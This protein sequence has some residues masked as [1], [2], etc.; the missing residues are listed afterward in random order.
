MP[1][2]W[3]DVTE[4]TLELGVG[5]LVGAGEADGAEAVDVVTMSRRAAAIPEEFADSLSVARSITSEEANAPF[6]AR[7]WNSPYEVGSQVTIVE[8]TEDVTLARVSIDGKEQGQFLVR[9]D[10]IAGM[11]PE[12]ILQHL[13]LPAVPTQI[14]E[15]VVPA[16]TRMQVGI[17]GPQP[18]FLNALGGGI[19]YQLLDEIP[20]ENFGTPRPLK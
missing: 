5:F 18:E 20:K 2:F 15:V 17:V 8:T 6:I 19:Q 12:Q 13:A 14:A 7:G 16:G 10:E 3:G 11:T 9:A 1:E 4:K